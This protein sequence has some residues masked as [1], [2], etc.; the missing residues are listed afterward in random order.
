M[1]FIMKNLIIIGARGYGREI[2]HFAKE[3][4]GYG[5]DFIIK[6]FLDDNSDALDGYDGYPPILDSVE[7]Y[8][9]EE[10]DVFTCAL[11][12]VNYKRKYVNLILSKGGEFINIIQSKE[13][14]LSNVSCI[15][16]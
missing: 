10:D 9:I 12:D 6:G 11:G 3:S 2:F 8:G 15:F 14:L 13:R 5:T 7:D 1:S 4:I 16:P